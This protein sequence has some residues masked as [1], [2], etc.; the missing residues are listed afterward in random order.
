MWPSILMLYFS[1]TAASA[2]S[3]VIKVSCVGDSITY[4]YL[5]TEGMTYPAQLQNLLGSGYK[6]SNFGSN[7]RT[8]LKSSDYPYWNT[9]QYQAALDSN[10]DIVVL[11]LGTNDAK[12]YNWGP[13]SS[14]YPIDYL[15]M[16][17]VFQSL[18]SRP[19]VF[20]MIPPPLYKDGQ[21]DMNQTVI[22]SF[23]PGTD[24]PG[25]IRAIAQTAGLPPP[26]DLFDV[27][28]AHCPVVQGTP[29]HN[30]SHELVTC[31]WIAHGGTDACHPN[32]SGYGQI[33]QA[34][35]HTLLEAMSRLRDAHLMS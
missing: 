32:N 4:G 7:G 11:M 29:G 15:D 21:Y 3:G 19:Q 13:H 9:S 28:Q 1:G 23:Y 8:M 24:L 26:I 22:N 14:E 20:T 33:A 25:S 12:Y 17:S 2:G 18:P 10:P 16:V 5:S 35:K 34:V 6:V 31:D 30:A 27:F